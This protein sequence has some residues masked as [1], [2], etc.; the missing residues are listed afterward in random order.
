MFAVSK[1]VEIS[2][3]KSQTYSHN[4]LVLFVIMEICFDAFSG[5]RQLRLFS[6]HS[7]TS[8]NAMLIV[9]TCCKKRTMM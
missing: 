6:H 3:Q 7:V 2:A 8:W 9:K 1:M 4:P 5:R